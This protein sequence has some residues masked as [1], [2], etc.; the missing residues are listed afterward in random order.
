MQDYKQKIA[1]LKWLKSV[2]VDHY[3]RSDINFKENI[4]QEI[5]S[6]APPESPSKV[7]IKSSIDKNFS[8]L[9]L[10]IN[11]PSNNILK[12]V[13]PHENDGMKAKVKNPPPDN[14][15]MIK[16][17]ELADGAKD[18]DSLKAIVENFDGCELKNLAINTV[19]ADGVRDAK[20]VL[21]GEAPGVNEDKMG[22]PFCGESGKLLDKMIETIGLSRKTNTYITNT[23]FWRPPANRRPTNE[24]I[25]ICRPFVEKHIALLN[26]EL[27][28]L[29]GAIAATSLLGKHD[30]ISNIR[31]NAY[32]YNNRYLSKP[33][34]MRALFHPAYL[35]RQPSQKKTT[36]YDLIRIQKHLA[37]EPPSG[38]IC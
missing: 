13:S 34:A 19:F 17:R 36:W 27:I 3:L 28:I 8:S 2:G 4:L 23:V 7:Q 6:M 11:T 14:N 10:E 25:D 9:R 29:V 22:I 38:K 33:I 15:A 35:L 16:A 32:S 24:E 37:T 31:K 30:G 20:V 18:I 12:E 26:P 21:I 1:Q 5:E